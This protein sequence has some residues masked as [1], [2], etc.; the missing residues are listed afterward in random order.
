MA[1]AFLIH[2]FALA[3]HSE[4][5]T[6]NQAGLNESSAFVLLQIRAPDA[7]PNR[8]KFVRHSTSTLTLNVLAG[9]VSFSKA[10]L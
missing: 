2:R 5:E 3:A 6:M 1:G 4:R 8:P 9:G 7:T 10:R